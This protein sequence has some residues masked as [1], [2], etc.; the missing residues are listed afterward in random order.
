[1]KLIPKRVINTVITPW[2]KGEYEAMLELRT[3]KPPVPAVPKVRVTLSKSD[4]PLKSK[5]NISKTERRP[6]IWKSPFII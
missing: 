4:M 6:P 2:Q 1:M 5:I 3:P